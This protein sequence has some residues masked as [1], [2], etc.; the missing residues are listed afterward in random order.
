MSTALVWAGVVMVVIV[1]LWGVD[2]LALWA[3]AGDPP[4]RTPLMDR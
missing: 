4:D 3:E 2:R 1:A